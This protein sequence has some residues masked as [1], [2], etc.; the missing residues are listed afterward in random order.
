M[1][2]EEGF[3]GNRVLRRAWHSSKEEEHT[4]A[5]KK[6]TIRQL[7]ARRGMSVSAFEEITCT[8]NRKSPCLSLCQA[9]PAAAMSMAGS[10][11][12]IIGGGAKQQVQNNRLQAQQ[13]RRPRKGCDHRI[14]SQPHGQH[15]PAALCGRR[16]EI[17]H[18]SFGPEGW[19][20]HPLRR[21]RGY[22]ARQRS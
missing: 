21:E 17:Y 5:I 11:F 3:Q 14:R 15:R 12:V 10:P 8:T 4:M 7:P 20:H 1:T 13:G 19:R 18:R 2:L 16:K 22:Q 9:R 6:I